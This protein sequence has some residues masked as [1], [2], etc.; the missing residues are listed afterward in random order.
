[1]NS[2]IIAAA[3]LLSFVFT[4]FVFAKSEEKGWSKKKTLSL[5]VLAILLG[6]TFSGGQALW[7]MLEYHVLVNK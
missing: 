2:S 7:E 6:F 4:W 1:M 3:S 5:F